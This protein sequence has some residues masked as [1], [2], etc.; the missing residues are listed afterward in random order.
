[1]VQILP[2]VPS[3]GSQLANVLGKA[4]SDIGQGFMDRST[5]QQLQNP[6]LTPMQRIALISS[7]P[8]EKAA[9]VASLYSPVLKEEAKMSSLQDVLGSQTQNN[10]PIQPT[11]QEGEPQLEGEQAVSP[12]KVEQPLWDTLSQQQKAKLSVR[13]PQMAKQF[14]SESYHEAKTALE[15]NKKY[16]ERIETIR[17]ELPNKRIA[18]M[19][20]Q[21]ALKNN[22][23]KNLGNFWADYTGNEYFKNESS[24]ALTSAVKEFLLQDIGTIKGGRPNQF[25]EKQL[26]ESYPRAGYDP[27]ANE[28]ISAA[29]QTG[30]DIAQKE[31]E[32]YSNLEDKYKGKLP[33]NISRIVNKDLKKYTIE[34]EQELKEKYDEINSR[35]GKALK[36]GQFESLPKATDFPSGKKIKDTKTGKTFQSNG[37]NWV[38][39]K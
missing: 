4:G 31:E 3:F 20:I 2:A 32:L 23:L 17:S 1:M 26:A 18:M 39:V 11:A 27:K 28:K 19:R 22:D 30:V 33:S 37:K 8:K 6:N 5:M 34:K 15:S 16:G 29:M 38:E 12:D 7:L 24:A 10:Q 35:K 36:A 13:F 21:D 25:I 9:V 14:E